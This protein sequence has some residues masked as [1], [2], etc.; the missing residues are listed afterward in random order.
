MKWLMFS[1]SESIS[2]RFLVPSTL[3]S[4]V[5]ASS[6]VDRFAS[7]TFVMESRLRAPG[8]VLPAGGSVLD[9]RDGEQTPPLGPVLPA[10]GSVL[11]VRDGEQTPPPARC[12]PLVSQYST[13]VMESRLGPPARCC[14][15][16]SQYS[17]FVMEMVAFETR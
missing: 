5:C 9:V 10:G 4:V 11:D 15:L 3:R 2:E 14:P 17:T 7:S 13:F 1:R 8:P 6:R 16:V 12:C